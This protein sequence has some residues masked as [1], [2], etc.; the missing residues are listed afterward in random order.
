MVLHLKTGRFWGVTICFI[1]SLPFGVLSG[2]PQ[3]SV[4]GLYLLIYNYLFIDAICGMIYRSAIDHSKFL[5]FADYVTIFLF[6]KLFDDGTQ[7]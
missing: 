3:G 2:V 4:L 5:L 7:L 1:L 6:V